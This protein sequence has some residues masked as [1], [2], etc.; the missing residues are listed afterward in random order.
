MLQ[1]ISTTK[2]PKPFSN[3]AQGIAVGPGHRPLFV[4][5]QVGADAEGDIAVIAR[6]GR[7]TAG[8][9]GQSDGGRNLQGAGHGDDVELH[10]L[11]AQ[12]VLGPFQKGV[13]QI[14][15]VTRLDDQDA[16]GVVQDWSSPSI[17]RQPTMRRP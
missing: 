2:A 6:R 12:G 1:E 13:S 16:G 4:A 17:S 7:I 8:L 14:V 9:L 10:A 11:R 5:G 3:Y 15:V